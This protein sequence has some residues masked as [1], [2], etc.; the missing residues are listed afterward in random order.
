MRVGR[1]LASNRVMG[2]IPDFPCVSAVQ[3]SSAVLPTGVTAPAPVMTTRPAS[4]GPSVRPPLRVLLDVADGVPDR[5]DLLRVL[6]RDL[7]IELLLEGH[8]ELDGIER[9]GP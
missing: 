3:N 4:P 5:G 1:G 2:P 8:H 7:E 6:V 9:I